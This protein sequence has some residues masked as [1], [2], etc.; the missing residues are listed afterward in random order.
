MSTRCQIQVFEY[1]DSENP[2]NTLY[3][4]SDGYPERVI[5]KIFE[6]YSYGDQNPKE[7]EDY[8]FLKGKAGK[9]ASLLC[10]T[11]PG[12]LEPQGNHHLYRHISYLYRL[13]VNFCN[14]PSDEKPLWEIEILERFWDDGYDDNWSE[15]QKEKYLKSKNYKIVTGLKVIQERLPIEELVQ[16]YI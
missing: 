15:D 9:I 8:N 10:W 16:K 7:F 1:R 5:P 2:I 4:H 11:D 14:F 6:A 12:H 3:L 13:Y